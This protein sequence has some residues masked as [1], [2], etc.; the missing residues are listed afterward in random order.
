MKQEE[1]QK[2][3]DS[4]DEGPLG[5]RKEWQWDLSL[6]MQYDNPLYRDDIKEEVSKKVSKTLTGRKRK[7][8]SNIKA[9]KTRKANGYVVTS[10]HKEK[11]R[12]SMLGKNSQ[13]VN[14]YSLDGELLQSYKSI[15]EASDH[16]NVSKNGIGNACA[17]RQ[18]T[19]KGFIWKYEK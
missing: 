4:L 14:R 19:C 17:G 6:R 11:I 16:I 15:K 9:I 2:L 7:K 8:S 13:K 1:L 10:K 12:Q 3:L 18:K 5:N